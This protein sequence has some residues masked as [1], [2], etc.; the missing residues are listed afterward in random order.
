MSQGAYASNGDG[1]RNSCSMSVRITN[2]K[3]V[4]SQCA[5]M[6]SFWP[7]VRIAWQLDVVVSLRRGLI[8]RHPRSTRLVRPDIQ[9]G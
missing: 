1:P 5:E 3:P 8:H 6:Y 9:H 2:R 7:P 4:V